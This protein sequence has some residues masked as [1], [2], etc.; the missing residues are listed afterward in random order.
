MT[1]I[2]EIA[3]LTTIGRACKFEFAAHITTRSGT[4]RPAKASFVG[5]SK[6]PRTRPYPKTFSPSQ[7]P[8]RS[9][10]TNASESM[11]K[12]M[13]FSGPLGSTYGEVG[14]GVVVVVDEDEEKEDV[15]F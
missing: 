14:L 3:T 12:I 1:V 4:A 13:I 11:L 8:A 15:V 9:E 2:N 7:T 10:S 5:T 6:N